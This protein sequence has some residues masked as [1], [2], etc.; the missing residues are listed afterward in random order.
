MRKFLCKTKHWFAVTFSELLCMTNTQHGIM[1]HDVS[2]G[3][4]SLNTL[5][6]SLHGFINLVRE[7]LDDRSVTGAVFS[8]SVSSAMQCSHFF[9]ASALSRTRWRRPVRMFHVTPLVR[10]TGNPCLSQSQ[11]N[12][13]LY[14]YGWKTERCNPLAKLVISKQ[15]S[16]HKRETLETLRYEDDG[17]HTTDDHV[18]TWHGQRR[19]PGGETPQQQRRCGRPDAAPLLHSTPRRSQPA[20]AKHRRQRVLQLVWRRPSSRHRPGGLLRP[21][22]LQT[23]QEQVEL[24]Q[25]AVEGGRRGGGHGSGADAG[26][27]RGEVPSPRQHR[28]RRGHAAE[29]HRR[30]SDWGG[31]GCRGA[32]TE[33]LLVVPWLDDGRQRPVLRAAARHHVRVPA[34]EAKSAQETTSE[35]A[36]GN[37]SPRLYIHRELATVNNCAIRQR[38]V[39]SWYMLTLNIVRSYHQG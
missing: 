22:A 10:T 39:L 20:Q 29:E 26:R 2:T 33:R 28:V 3:Q 25:A 32:D 1:T 13:D 34:E 8:R 38:S 19:L 35:P 9:Q 7:F 14:K 15:A 18:L 30:R 21:S 37:I 12:V 5:G 16:E 6:N 27:T 17:K 24:H 36:V 4:S 31:G 11:R 23:R